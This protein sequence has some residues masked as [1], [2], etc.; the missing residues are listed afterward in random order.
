MTAI[1]HREQ[2]KASGAT[3]RKLKRNNAHVADYLDA[4]RRM[5][6]VDFAV[7][8]TGP[9]GSGKTEFVKSWSE[10]LTLQDNDDKPD[11]LSVSL[12]GVATLDEVDSLLFR[13]AHPVL[14]GKSV[15]IAAKVMKTVVSEK[16]VLAEQLEKVLS[17]L[18]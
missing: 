9:W 14:G 12:N 13:A 18:I 6:N 11:F 8:V 16:K 7:M 4:Y 3:L 5:G 10:T 17:H 15:R 1:K 2:M